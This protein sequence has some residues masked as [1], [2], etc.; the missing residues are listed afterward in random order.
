MVAPLCVKRLTGAAAAVPCSRH[1]FA[2]SH[3]LVC[4]TEYYYLLLLLKDQNHCVISINSLDDQHHVAHNVRLFMILEFG[5]YLKLIFSLQLRFL[6]CSR[7]HYL[8]CNPCL[9]QPVDSSWHLYRWSCNWSQAFYPR[10]S[11][12]KSLYLEFRRNI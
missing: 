7:T 6:V 8:D 9:R 4:T 2:S 5:N 11:D 12:Q 3:L 1:L 10:M